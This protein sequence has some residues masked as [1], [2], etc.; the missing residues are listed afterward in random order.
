[1][2]KEDWMRDSDFAMAR[3]ASSYREKER[4]EGWWVDFGDNRIGKRFGE[5]VEGILEDLK[6]NERA[7][8]EGE[9][10]WKAGT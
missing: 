1:M 6:G 3:D 9:R 4:G 2:T 5:E 7:K 10:V 8:G